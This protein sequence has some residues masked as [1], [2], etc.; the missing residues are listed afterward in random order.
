MNYS[1]GSPIVLK[2]FILMNK[3]SIILLFCFGCTFLPQV[4]PEKID[5]IPDWQDLTLRE[6]IAQMVMVRITGDFYSEENNYRNNLK[7]W[8]NDDG[9]GGVITFGGSI[10]GTFYNIQQFQSWAN[11]PLFV[12]A[13]YERGT[14][15]WLKNGVLFPTNMAITATGNPHNAYIQ[16]QITAQEAKALGVHITF[17]PVLD[18]N[19]NPN[20]PIIN[21]RSYSDDAETVSKFGTAFIQG[22]QDNGIIACAKHYPGHG[23]TDIDSHTSLPII[24]NSR[25]ELLKQE[26]QPFKAAVD[27]GVKM[28]MTAHISLPGIDSTMLPASHS[29]QITHEILRNQWGYNGL[30]VT[31]GLEM[32]A[33]TKQAWAGES[34]IRAVEAGADILLLPIDVSHTIQALVSA[35]EAGRISEDRI[36]ESVNRIW[37]AKS[38]AG[39]FEKNSYQNFNDVERN[40]NL[41]KNRISAKRLAQESITLVKDDLNLLPLKPENIGKIVHI[42]ISTDDDVKDM[43]NPFARDIRYTHREVD[44][45]FVQESISDYRIDEFVNIASEADM[46][47]ISLLVRIR[48]DK[49]VATINSTHAELLERLND[50]EIPFVAISFGSPYLPDYSTIPTYVCTYGYGSVSL[51]AA[52]DAIWG[53]IPVT[54]K[55][56][57]N[58]S[59]I[60]P[61]GSGI[62]R[63]K[64]TRSFG[65]TDK[66]D[67]TPAW[68]VIDSAINEQ[69]FPGAQVVI[70]KDGNIAANAGFGHH[71]YDNKSPPVTSESVYDLASLTKVVATTPVFMKLASQKKISLDH[72]VS[73]YF[74]EFRGNRKDIV[75]IKHLITHSSGLPG[76][77]EFFRNPTVQSKTDIIDHILQQDLEYYPGTDMVYSDLGIILLGAII[78]KVSGTQLDTLA[79]IYLF[80]PL[81]MTSTYFNPNIGYQSRIVP[82]EIDS[83]YRKKLIHGEVHDENAWL[84]DG[85]APHAGLFSTGM[86][87]AKYGQCLVN[88]GVWNGRR[89]FNSSQIVEYT[90][91]QNLPPGSDR[92]IGWDSPSRNGKSSAGDYFSEN[93]FG[94]LGFT[95]TS[96][97]VD[98]D[99]KIIVIL[100]TNRVHPTRKKGGMYHVR[101][102]FHTEVMKTLLDQNLPVKVSQE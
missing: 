70:V 91:R 10:H 88:G 24:P 34:A 21:F 67:F 25:D 45:Y 76:Y 102:R 22:I 48:M 79:E 46:T 43:L 13:D 71:T 16:G 90:T 40:V 56:P 37:K 18:I 74:P 98:P 3:F 95:G 53:R 85:V 55:L 15:Q 80:N 23:N 64:V 30:I 26:F 27:S 17:S 93:S 100:L 62:N 49:G 69:I 9:I 47:I 83:A 51:R 14:G 31:D 42:Q 99:E 92:A 81:G 12:A 68:A 36:N 75:T 60:F 41:S 38:G 1:Q 8:I 87:L 59:P 19:N 101:R 82:T 4:S 72:T 54:G 32:G 94:H 65:S 2:G 39:V 89:V 35:V 96:L 78:E 52:A 20:N 63:S 6:K 28:I 58:L 84:M 50:K 11:I 97:W 77:I 33:L 44:E 7:K 5:E 57:V 29:P 66:F 73:Q 61:R 86:D